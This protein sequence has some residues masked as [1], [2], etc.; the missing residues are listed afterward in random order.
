MAKFKPGDKVVVDFT[1]GDITSLHLNNPK[2]FVGYSPKELQGIQGSHGFILSEYT[3]S[4]SIG[5]SYLVE[6]KLPKYL[7]SIFSGFGHCHESGQFNISAK[8][9]KFDQNLK[10]EFY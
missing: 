1:T 7:Q 3:I 4:S 8:D 10:L 9:L 2:F 6:L 5:E